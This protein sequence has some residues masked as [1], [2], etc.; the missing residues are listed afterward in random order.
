LVASAVDWRSA[1]FAV[2]AAGLLLVPLFRAAVKEP[3][4]STAA[5]SSPGLF[6]T[7]GVL[8]PKPSFWL[9]SLGAGS[10]SLMG[11]G[12]IFWL[13]SF[14]QRSLHLSLAETAKY[15]GAI[16]LIGGL[17]GV[18]TGGL[19]ADLFGKRRGAYALVPAIAFLLA[20]PCYIGAITAPS[21]ESAFVLFLLPQALALA[22]L[23]PVI[24]AVQHLTPP[25]MRATASALFLFI[26]NLIGLGLGTLYLGAVSDLLARQ[27]GADSLKYA[28]LSGLGFYALSAV[29]LLFAAGRLKRDW[30][31]DG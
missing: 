13:P 21:L 25:S 28:I 22:W 29:L 23:G 9:L 11:Y 3:P 20:I 8:L 26:N 24:A 10:S 15:Y 6:E 19:L 14:F 5:A 27:F 12:L 31:D 7:L 1:F 18:W 30:V 4:R 17:A 2:G 16:L